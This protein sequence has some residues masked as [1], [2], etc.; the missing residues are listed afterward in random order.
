MDGTANHFFRPRWSA[1]FFMYNLKIF[2]NPGVWTRSALQ[3]S[4]C[5]DLTKR[6]LA[7]LCRH[8]A[9]QFVCWRDSAEDGGKRCTTSTSSRSAADITSASNRQ[10]CRQHRRRRR[11]RSDVFD[12]QP[13]SQRGHLFRSV[14]HLSS[15]IQRTNLRTA[16]VTYCFIYLFIYT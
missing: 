10:R 7:R 6:P 3:R 14:V 16:F 11:R 9:P 5:S 13:V 2:P 1:G 4:R 12:E 8:E 15:R